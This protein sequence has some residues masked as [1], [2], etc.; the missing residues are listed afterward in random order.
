MPQRGRSERDGSGLNVRAEAGGKLP[1][2]YTD[3]LEINYMIRDAAEQGPILNVIPGDGMSADD[4][5][6][7]AVAE[8]ADAALRFPGLSSASALELT[9]LHRAALRCA[10][11]PPSLSARASRLP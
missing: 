2:S 7:T 5:A 10:R 8:A 3:G 6:W 9:E 11:Q 4:A 1:H